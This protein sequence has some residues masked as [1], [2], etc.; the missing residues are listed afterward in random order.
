MVSEVLNKKRKLNIEM[1]RK[2]HKFLDIPIEILV[3]DY[4][5]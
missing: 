3:Q 4:S 5:F 2:L 1:I